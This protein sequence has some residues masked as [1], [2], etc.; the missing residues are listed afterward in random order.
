[1]SRRRT[2]RVTTALVVPMSAAL[3]LVLALD[4]G[5]AVAATTD[6]TST[7]HPP[8]SSTTAPP[9]T[10]TTA[11]STTTTTTPAKTPPTKTAP[12]TAPSA[13]G[14]VTAAPPTLGD[15]DYRLPVPAALVAAHPSWIDEGPT[16][17]TTSRTRPA[18]PTAFPVPAGTRVLAVTAGHIRAVRNEVVDGAPQSVRRTVV[19]VGK[20]GASYTY[21]DVVD[22]V[23]KAGTE[24][25]R[26]QHLGS[27]GPTGI[28][29]GIRVPDVA[30]TVD[31]TGALQAWAIGTTVDIHS[32]PRT[33]VSSARSIATSSR[34]RHILVVTDRA[35][36]RTGTDLVKALAGKRV[37]VTTLTVH[38]GRTTAQQAAAIR[39]S[40]VVE[41]AVAAT[42]TTAARA[43]THDD[44]VI[45]ALDTATP[46]QARQI[47]WRIPAAD[48]ILWVTPPAPDG[49][50]AA[51]AAAARSA[52]QYLATVTAHP[53]LRV[54]TLPS[55]LRTVTTA[56]TKTTPV[57]LPVTPAALA[58]MAS[59]PAWSRT[60]AQVVS[61]L[62][63]TYAG[64]AYRLPLANA[65]VGKVLAYGEAQL[66][67]PYVWG[68]AGPSSFDCSGLVMEA[69]DQVGID[70]VHNAYAQYEATKAERVSPS[71]LQAGD[72]VFFGP[73]EAGI[74]H[75]G[76]YVG[77]GE[78][79][80]APET[81]QDVQIE[82]MA[83]FGFY[84]A[85]DPLATLTGT[86]TAAGIAPDQAFARAL[87]DTTWGPGQWTYLDELWNRE[88][89][90]NPDATNPTSGAFG[91]P[92]ALPAT[93]LA[94]AGADW[95]T[96]PY[97]Q[98][99]WGIDYISQRYGTP[100]VAWAHE[101]ADGWY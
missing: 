90:W 98:I 72:L 57:V 44:L 12:T 42:P 101:M 61:S 87:A 19:L 74:H 16:A 60:G 84:A 71:N 3:G 73:T 37:K 55:A 80:D 75:V 14:V 79:L 35:T 39:S 99:I 33:R 82:S 51:R 91:I 48:N 28:T 89:G 45:V 9:T 43:A 54:E 5:V 63:T 58:T 53:N 70:F 38:D 40:S 46:L 26:G 97:T 93:K 86:S 76:I 13:G 1:V 65:A 85:T 34:T 10:G 68:G 17:A 6:T 24:I 81:G 22:P 100:Q 50:G 88:S 8:A 23:V 59:P 77:N 11:P 31:A 4:S 67:K 30:G 96:D 83:G 94:T 69:F 95:A 49:T 27:A 56:P 62:V 21:T 52:A 2:R 32:L 7:T 20:D 29:F 66:G 25:R 18:R 36:G 64:T 41:P 15:T 92:Q 78:M 47:M